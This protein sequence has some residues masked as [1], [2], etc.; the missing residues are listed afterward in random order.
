[1]DLILSIP[2][3]VVKGGDHEL[4]ILK[5]QRAPATNNNN[6]NNNNAPCMVDTNNNMT[7]PTPAVTP[8]IAECA[9]GNNHDEFMSPNML[10][11]QANV[12]MVLSVIHSLPQNMNNT[13]FD[14]IGA[15]VNS[16]Q[17]FNDQ[18]FRTMKNN[19]R[20]YGGTIASAFAHQQRQQEG[21]PSPQQHRRCMVFMEHRTQELHLLIDL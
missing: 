13:R 18:M 15:T 10:H 6:N 21:A 2:L 5:I 3:H 20:R 12:H 17:Q 9:D 19:I 14:E 1:L 4:V 11:Y 7:T 16:N 8:F